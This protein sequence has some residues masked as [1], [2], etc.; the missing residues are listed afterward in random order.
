MGLI[1]IKDQAIQ[2]NGITNRKRDFGRV[3][4]EFV[5][6]DP[7]EFVEAISPIAPGVRIESLRAGT[8]R[9]DVRGYP[10]SRLGLMRVRTRNLWVLDQS[11]RAYTGITI[12][13]SSGFNVREQR[14]DE[15]FS[16]GSAH[17]LNA[18]QPFDFRARDGA[19]LVVNIDETHLADLGVKLSGGREEISP[20]LTPRLS[21]SDEEGSAFWRDASRLWR[22]VGRNTPV[23][24]SPLAL[25][26]LEESVVVQLLRADRSLQSHW[27]KLSEGNCRH[28]RLT[29]VED[30]IAANLHEP[31]SRADICQA[32]GLDVRTLSR[33]FQK[34]YGMGP[35]RFVRA[36][37]L[38]TVNRLLLGLDPAARTVTEIALDYGFH[39]LSRF[40]GDY[41]RAFGEAPSQTLKR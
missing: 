16:S 23:N 26:E 19:V 12:S 36:R 31:L 4:V 32:A 27:Q 22:A 39:H 6:R 18:D 7:Q 25:R 2:C 15:G 40:A 30:W 11:P 21:L 5:T 17:V 13:L 1:P 20:S 9:A 3:H 8:F 29:Q 33:A 34:K 38:D 35:M 28:A 10:L 24:R 37:R 41:Q 14:K